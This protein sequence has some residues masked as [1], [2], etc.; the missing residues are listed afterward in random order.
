MT[1]TWTSASE[2]SCRA[3]NGS[4]PGVSLLCP[5][6]KKGQRRLT[7][8]KTARHWNK[9][10]F[11]TPGCLYLNLSSVPS[12]FKSGIEP[13][14]FDASIGGCEPPIH[15]GCFLVA[16]SFPGGGFSD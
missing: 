2:R 6:A 10:Q 13:L 5:Q 16:L 14:Q 12:V 15:S 3:I 8:A 1:R 7:Q 9:R 11:Y 4:V